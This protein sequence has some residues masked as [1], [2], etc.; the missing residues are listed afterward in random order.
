MYVMYFIP[1]ILIFSVFIIYAAIKGR[2]E[3]PRILYSIVVV[4]F[5]PVSLNIA[6]W[7]LSG[8]VGTGGG[9]L[10]LALSFFIGWTLIWIGG[11]LSFRFGSLLIAIG[12]IMNWSPFGVGIV[13]L[14]LAYMLK[15]EQFSRKF[16]ATMFAMLV[17]F[18]LSIHN[19][20][21]SPT[22]S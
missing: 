14:S 10:S 12:A 17:S 3:D 6:S 11:L 19:I 13:M 16:L 21:S 8:Y 20:L 9:L 22:L 15:T 18:S 2:I 7:I 1:L 4:S 5:I